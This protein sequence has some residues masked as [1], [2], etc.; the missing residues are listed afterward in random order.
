MAQPGEMIGLLGYQLL[1]GLFGALGLALVVRIA[2]LAGSAPTGSLVRVRGGRLLRLALADR[3]RL[4]PA[5]DGGRGGLDRVAAL[6]AFGTRPPILGVGPAAGESPRTG[7]GR[8]LGR[9]SVRGIVATCGRHHRSAGSPRTYG[10]GPAGR[11]GGTAPVRRRGGS[12]ARRWSSCLY[13]HRQPPASSGER[14]PRAD[15]SPWSQRW[16]P[17]AVRRGRQPTDTRVYGAN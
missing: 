3:T 16:R 2:D 4:R 10:R 5:R 9:D 8:R 14:R 12:A 13:S 15:W 11:G 6:G 7:G 17:I 1:I